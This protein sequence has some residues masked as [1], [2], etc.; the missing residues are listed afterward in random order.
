DSGLSLGERI[1][2]AYWETEKVKSGEEPESP[3]YYKNKLSEIVSNIKSEMDKGNDAEDVI[4]TCIY[5]LV[6]APENIEYRDKHGDIPLTKTLSSGKI[7]CCSSTSLYLI[8]SEAIKFDLFEKY[9]IGRVPR[10]VFIRKEKGE[11]YEN[12]DQGKRSNGNQHKFGRNDL[13]KTEPKEFILSSILYNC[14]CNLHIIQKRYDESIECYN[15]A[16]EINP[17]EEIVWNSKGDAYEKIGDYEEA[18]KCYNKA[19]EINN[20]QDLNRLEYDKR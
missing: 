6:N 10:H 7:S 15:K 1:M 12:I 3:N 17:D 16:L 20:R 2:E 8:L 11:N 13:P 5:E 19:L 18:F 14:G 9:N 4:N